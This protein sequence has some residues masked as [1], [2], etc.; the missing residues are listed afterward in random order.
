MTNTPRRSWTAS[1]DPAASKWPIVIGLSV[2]LIVTL[3]I[4]LMNVLSKDQPRTFAVS[5]AVTEYSGKTILPDP[6]FA[7][8]NLDTFTQAFEQRGLEKWSVLGAPRTI[9][10]KNQFNLELAKPL[11]TAGVHARD[12]LIVYLRCHALVLND[13]AY[14]LTGDFSAPDALVDAELEQRRAIR[15]E[16]LFR[17]FTQLPVANVVVLADV[18]DLQSVPQLGVMANNV[19]EQIG[20]DCL[21]LADLRP[22]SKL[23]VITAAAPLQANH[24][25]FLR[26]QTLLQ[27]ACEYACDAKRSGKESKNDNLALSQFYD[28][29][30]RYSHHVTD[31]AQTPWLFHSGSKENITPQSPAW[32]AAQ[33]VVMARRLTRSAIQQAEALK[34]EQAEPAAATKAAQTAAPIANAAAPVANAA[35][36]ESPAPEPTVETTPSLRY[37]QIRDALLERNSNAGGW[38]PVD[39]HLSAWQRIQAEML[40]LEHRERLLNFTGENT[41][42]TLRDMQQ[43]IASLEKLGQA[44]RRDGP[45][46]DGDELLSAWNRLIQ[47]LDSSGRRPWSA[48]GVLPDAEQQRW[49]PIRQLYRDYIDSSAPLSSWLG[50]AL[51]DGNNWLDK[52]ERYADSLRAVHKQLPATAESVALD[53]PL[54][55]S[56]IQQLT[57]LQR[58]TLLNALAAHYRQHR[59]RCLDAQ[60]EGGKPLQWSTEM[61]LQL[62]L[63]SPLLSYEQRKELVTVYKALDKSRLSQP[64]DENNPID[65][66]QPLDALLAN[67][68]TDETLRQFVRWSSVLRSLVALA[69][70]GSD[71][72][73]EISSG[74][75]AALNQWGRQLVS[76]YGSQPSRGPGPATNW[77]RACLSPWGLFQQV[78]SDSQPDGLVIAVSADSSID[79]TLSQSLQLPNPLILSLK[80]RNGTPVETCCVVWRLRNANQFSLRPDQLLEVRE[81]NGTPLPPGQ[82]HI[83]KVYGGQ[84]TLQLASELTSLS[85]T[86]PIA[87]ELEVSEDER[88]LRPVIRQLDISPANPDS[89]ELYAKPAQPPLPPQNQLP[90]SQR[91]TLGSGQHSVLKSLRVPVVEGRPKAIYELYAYNVSD[92]DKWVQATV[93]DARPGN[94]ELVGSGRVTSGAINR[95]LNLLENNGRELP[96]VYISTP[97]FLPKN[98]EGVRIHNF[99]GREPANRQR[100]VFQPAATASTPA[101]SETPTSVAMIGEFGLLCVIREIKKGD[102]DEITILNDKE[103]TLHWID[104]AAEN[105]VRSF[106]KL[107][108]LI[109]TADA[110]KLTMTVP[111]E[112]WARW[113]V[114]EM[115][116]QWKLTNERGNEVG[117]PESPAGVLNEQK[118]TLAWTISPSRPAGTNTPLVVHL[119]V[120]G[121]P[122]AINLQS[123]LG[124]IADEAHSTPQSFLWVDPSRL[125]CTDDAGQELQLTQ[126]DAERF[127]VP[128]RIGASGESLGTP[129]NPAKLTLPISADF[130]A[131]PQLGKQ[132]QVTLS[133]TESR[134]SHDR[135]IVPRFE[136]ND[137]NLRFSADVQD[138]TYQLD[139]RM[140]RLSQEQRLQ[141]NI[142][143]DPTVSAGFN[144]IFD[145][146]PPERSKVEVQPRE[147]YL[148]DSVRFSIDL[149]DDSRVSEVYFA[150]DDPTF[151]PGVYDKDDLLRVR[152]SAPAGT[153]SALLDGTPDLNTKLV[154][155][156][157]YTVVCRSIDAAGNIRDDHRVGVFRWTNTKRP[158]DRPKPPTAA[159]KQP[160]PKPETNEYTVV[161]RVTVAGQTPRFPEKTAVDGLPGSEPVHGGNAA[162]TI[163]KVPQGSYEVTASYVDPFGTKH[164]GKASINVTP[165]SRRS[166]T[167]DVKRQ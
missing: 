8:W 25:S 164:A 24:D 70:S 92:Q 109:P 76:E 36:P 62:L 35:A 93:Y 146:Q 143:N 165:D 131:D 45:T 63:H 136:L 84:A 102:N 55:D 137:G 28:A 54:V 153:W 19:V 86:T 2:L 14:A 132:L 144:L 52:V 88:R 121:Y 48:P 128:N 51:Q 77:Y 147:L 116:V 97:L 61:R 73:P 152:A 151:N 31:G 72:L 94:G 6:A 64:G 33:N 41:A 89:I 125:V 9:N 81:A 71:P 57:Y 46:V 118:S 82:P 160:E 10:I 110:F 69:K 150:I 148:E 60:R 22:T 157:D 5:A 17:Q 91:V 4:F 130:S 26:G 154:P 133:E 145:Q 155:G 161:V 108:Q 13:Q 90:R 103:P 39:L 43:Y 30:V 18:C 20:V 67:P 159:A 21:R 87:I 40:A 138:L 135:K 80:R 3:V 96:P 95:T 50:L 105:P 37:W 140:L 123:R 66:R 75:A 111:N 44:V 7:K 32:K 78:D 56:D 1:D 65:S 11:Q 16:E 119:D 47:E 114:Q 42:P 107:P 58:E 68:G 156:R 85:T 98:E 106:A 34:N 104:I 120:G 53:Y 139:I 141:F 99:A 74:N 158:A 112:H 15:F 124:A 142:V 167:I 117:F 129:V 162:W 12:T 27:A 126:L 100:L 122:R 149:V 115:N 101:S 23:W 163:T 59:D 29:L 166:I 49:Q 134:Y 83:V 127:V 38:S 79:M 113:G